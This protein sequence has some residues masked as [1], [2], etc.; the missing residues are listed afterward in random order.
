MHFERGKKL[1]RPP[2]KS[3][4]LYQMTLFLIVCFFNIFIELYLIDHVL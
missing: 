3:S 1:D 2:L 4:Y